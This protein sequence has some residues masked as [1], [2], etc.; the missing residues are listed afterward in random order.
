[1]KRTIVTLVLLFVSLAVIARSEKNKPMEHTEKYFSL[2]EMEVAVAQLLPPKTGKKNFKE[3]GKDLS[4][5]IDNITEYLLKSGF[6]E[7]GNLSFKV[8]WVLI[9]VDPRFHL[10]FESSI[11]HMKLFVPKKNEPAEEV[12]ILNL[13]PTYLENI[14]H[15]LQSWYFISQHLVRYVKYYEVTTNFD[16]KRSDR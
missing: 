11:T 13:T 10:Y 1:M 7:I 2:K 6:K 16:E 9:V 5:A 14:E 3:G 8:P 4:L 12:Y 15:R